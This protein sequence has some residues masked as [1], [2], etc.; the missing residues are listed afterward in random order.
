[1]GNTAEVLNSPV[2]NTGSD[3]RIIAEI[4]NLASL[5]A[6]RIAQQGMPCKATSKKSLQLLSSFENSKSESILAQLKS[7]E[8]AVS[9]LE[10]AIDDPVHPE[11]QLVEQSLNFFGF[12]LRDD[13]WATVDR[14]DI[15]QVFNGEGIQVF[16]TFNFF[17][18]SGYSLTDLLTQEWYH[19]WERPKMVLDSLLVESGRILSGESSGVQKMHSLPHLLKEVYNAEDQEGFQSRSIYVEMKYICPLYKVGEKGPAGFILSTKAE[20]NASGPVSDNLNFI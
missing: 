17:H 15:I 10:K 3:H 12:Y 9:E 19:L 7:T 2:M 14:N 1:M 5:L 18:Y 4:V 11:K 13:F 16:R 8:M 20:H 6:A